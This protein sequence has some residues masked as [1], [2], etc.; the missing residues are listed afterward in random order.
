MAESG[1][2]AVVVKGDNENT[3][4]TEG[5]LSIGQSSREVAA[6]EA[7]GPHK[8]FI[9]KEAK[10]C[11]NFLHIPEA[12]QFCVPAASWNVSFSDCA[13]QLQWR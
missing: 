8:R 7:G 12:P 4:A 2:N 9:G 13:C 5:T 6:L 1:L 3:K 11:T 10:E